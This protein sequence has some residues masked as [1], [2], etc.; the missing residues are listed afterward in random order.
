MERERENGRC[1][2]DANGSLACE[3]F[4]RSTHKQHPNPSEQGIYM[5][6]YNVIS[7][8]VCCVCVCV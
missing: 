2:Y 4:E 7:V 5:Y 3:V 6:H 1:S 8:C